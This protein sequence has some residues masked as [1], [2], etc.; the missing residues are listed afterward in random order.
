MEHFRKVLFWFWKILIHTNEPLIR[1]YFG[2][3]WGFLVLCSAAKMEKSYMIKMLFFFVFFLVLHPCAALKNIPLKEDI[4]CSAWVLDCIRLR[5]CCLRPSH[6]LVCACA[7]RGAQL[8]VFLAS[9]CPCLLLGS[10]SEQSCYAC[11]FL[12]ARGLKAGIK[13]VIRSGWKR[14]A[15]RQGSSGADQ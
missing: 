1:S 11:K 2:E 14:E 4:Y 5:R 12:R 13:D 3:V 15:E 10:I 6:L 9:L 7:A 8:A